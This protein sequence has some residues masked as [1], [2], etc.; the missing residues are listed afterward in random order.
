M[1]QP[2]HHRGLIADQAGGRSDEQKGDERGSGS[3]FMGR[4]SVDK[5]SSDNLIKELETQRKDVRF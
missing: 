1:M 5:Q 4:R 3:P 2:D